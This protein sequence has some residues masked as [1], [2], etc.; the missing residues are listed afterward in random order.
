MAVGHL[1]SAGAVF[2]IKHALSIGLILCSCFLLQVTN[3]K[4]VCKMLKLRGEKPTT[5]CRGGICVHWHHHSLQTSGDNYHLWQQELHNL[6]LDTKA[7]LDVLIVVAIAKCITKDP[8]TLIQWI[9][10]SARHFR[11]SLNNFYNSQP[12]NESYV[13]YHKSQRN[14]LGKHLMTLIISGWQET[15]ELVLICIRYS[16]FSLFHQILLQAIPQHKD[17]DEWSFVSITHL[18]TD[19]A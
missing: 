3:W 17:I 8:N 18:H 15:T 1:V 13:L 10:Q 5:S 14:P 12:H 16:K 4:L 9:V 19:N 11:S 7:V 2:C 6:K